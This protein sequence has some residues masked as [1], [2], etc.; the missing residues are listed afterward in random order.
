[1]ILKKEIILLCKVLLITNLAWSAQFQQA[2]DSSRQRF[3]LRTEL[4]RQK[5]ILSRRID[6]IFKDSST[7]DTIPDYIVITDTVKTY[8]FTRDSLEKISIKGLK[9]LFVPCYYL[10]RL[11]YLVTTA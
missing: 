11:K 2:N 3:L 5:L 6:S 9:D 10:N 1:M 7:K 4:L 8:P